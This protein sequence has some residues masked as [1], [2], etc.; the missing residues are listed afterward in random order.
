MSERL[1]H[2]KRIHFPA[3]LI[4][5]RLDGCLQKMSGSLRSQRIRNYPPCALVVFHPCW[6]RQSDPYRTPADKKLYVN[7]IRVAGGNGDNQG[8]INAMQLLSGPAV[9]SVKVLVH[10]I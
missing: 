9:G 6:M 4:G 1:I 7:G 5:A 8:L 10:A 2:R 3:M